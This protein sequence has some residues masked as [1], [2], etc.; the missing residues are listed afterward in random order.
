MRRNRST[1]LIFLSLALLLSTARFRAAVPASP[2]QRAIDFNDAAAWKGV[3]AT[4]L[5]D[6]GDW[7]GYR[8]SPQ[9]GDSGVTIRQTNGIK[10][11]KFSIGEIPAA[12]AAGGPPAGGLV[13]GAA[14]AISSDSK[15]AAFTMF[16]SHAEAAQ[17]KRQRKPI[18]SKVGIVNLETGE[19]IEV[20]KVR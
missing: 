2:E 12:A 16:P 15:Y 18:Q 17:L 7:F 11:Y 8:L 4:A 6:H 10:E 13:G 5:A 20:A 1:V 9:E 19:K 14:L 3:N